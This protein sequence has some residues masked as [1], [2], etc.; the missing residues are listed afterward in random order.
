[1]RLTI[2]EEYLEYSIGGGKMKAIKLRNLPVGLYQK[3]Y[4]LGYT[5]FFNVEE[6]TKKKTYD[7]NNSGD[8]S[9][10]ISN[11]DGEGNI[12]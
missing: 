9:I 4:D 12:K 1:M 10:S 3:Y 7:K 6:I 5:Q 2:K 8:N 11:T